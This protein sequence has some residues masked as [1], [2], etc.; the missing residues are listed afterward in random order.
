MSTKT[1]A[2]V[3]IVSVYGSTMVAQV[4]EGSDEATD[5]GMRPTRDRDRLIK[6]ARMYF[7]DGRS[8]QDIA[9]SLGT[10]RSNVSRILSAAREQ[11][12]VQIRIIE[13]TERNIQLER[14]LKRKFAITDARVLAFRPSQ[15]VID[16]VGELASLWMLES[17][18]PGDV[19]GLSWGRNLHAAVA[20]TPPTPLPDIELVQL[21]G[22][23]S[24]L[25]SNVSGQEL[26]RDL[27]KQFGC[28]YR[29]L[30][31]PATFDNSAALRTLLQE[32]SIVSTLQAASKAD[33]ALVGIGSYGVGS[34]AEIVETLSLSQQ[35]RA[36]FEGRSPVGDVCAR[37]FDAEGREIDTVINE[38]VLA[39]TL[40]ELRH[41]P[42]V[43]GVVSG[44]HK[45]AGV[46]GALRAGLVDVLV[47]DAALAASV[48]TAVTN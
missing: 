7:Q 31:A 3:L 6:V 45:T 36:R 38:R 20:A 13:P 39:I 26:V 46:L 23:L 33:V 10:T 40:D 11:G 47:C 5:K 27:A 41:I 28:T 42:L 8:Q 2:C 30:H 14:D 35:E 22:G 24:T 12:I 37:F 16:G 43:V 19:V 29:Y 34:S 25:R 4:A 32:S 48:L 21:V 17:L 15:Q 44:E 9:K 18:Q 1:V